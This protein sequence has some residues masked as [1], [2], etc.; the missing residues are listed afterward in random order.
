[1]RNSS[2]KDLVLNYQTELFTK[3]GLPFTF[4]PS[5]VMRLLLSLSVVCLAS[6]TAR[7]QSA[8]NPTALTNIE[9]VNHELAKGK[10]YTGAMPASG[11]SFL[12][13]YWTRG[14]VKMTSGTVPQPWLKYDLHG[15]RLL[16]RR[17][18]GDSLELN[19][20][21]TTEFSLGDSLRGTRYLYR[22]YLAARIRELPLRTAFFEVRYDAGRSA[23][24]RRRSRTLF[25]GNNGP[26]LAGRS[27]DRWVETSVFYLKNA[28]NV[29]EPIRLGSKAVLAVLG[30]AKAPALQGYA[31]REHLDLSAEA[32]IVQLLKYYD[33]L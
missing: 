2:K 7:A 25:H 12:L 13:P 5:L 21:T 11:S 26:S 6:L 3:L 9:I 28:D 15:D 16:W 10:G 32:D 17:P 14:T 33:T 23:L 27:G 30:K 1:M 31:T 24:L 4:P 19:T 20:S 29:I 8:I 18:N 22:R